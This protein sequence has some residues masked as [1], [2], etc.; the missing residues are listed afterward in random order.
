MNPVP[1]TIASAYTILREVVTTYTVVDSHSDANPYVFLFVENT[2]NDGECKDAF[3]YEFTL[4]AQCVHK[5][6]QPDNSRTI[7]D[8]VV[9]NVMEAIMPE[10]D[11]RILVDNANVITQHFSGVSYQTFDVIP[12]GTTAYTAEVRYFFRVEDLE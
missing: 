9:S 2:P 4:V 5:S 1:A 6:S 12:E 7:L 3:I 10:V 8:N 11:T